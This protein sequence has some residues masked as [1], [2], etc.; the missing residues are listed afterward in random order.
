MI[1]FAGGRRLQTADVSFE[2]TTPFAVVVVSSLTKDPIAGASRLLVS[3]SGD[4]RW[5]GTN[6]SADG[7]QVLTTG[8]FPF[9]MQPIEGRL[10]IKGPVAAVYRLDTDG[11][12]LGPLTVTPAGDGV[13]LPLA[14]SNRAMHYEVVRGATNVQALNAERQTPNAQISNA[15]RG[16]LVLRSLHEAHR[17]Q[18]VGAPG[19]GRGIRA[20]PSSHLAGA[21]G[22][23][24]G[25]RRAGVLDLPRPGR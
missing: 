12:R 15:Q 6:V 2:L 9:L 3:T 25:P 21:R 7:E 23:A 8:R 11:T 18:D 4:A 13:E 5:T 10:R 19:E 22:R 20:A 24:P 1:G 14:A 16:R 17:V